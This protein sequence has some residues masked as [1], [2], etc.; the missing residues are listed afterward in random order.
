MRP[1]EPFPLGATWDGRGTNF[2]IFSEV[3]ERVELC[4]FDRNGRETRV[5]LPERTAFCWH[6][7]LRGV[8]PGQRYGFRVHGPWDPAN[9]LRCNP[10]KLLVD[11]YARAIT[12]GIEWNP[13]VFPYPLGGD[14]LQRDDDDNAAYMPKA[15]VVDDAFDWEGDRSAAP[16]AARDGHLRSAPE[17]IHEAASRI[18]RRPS[19]ARMPGSRTRPRSSTCRRS[20]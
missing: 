14:D 9:G 19:A 5:N 15:V 6:A 16:Q 2:S 7:Y 12:G 13:P 1:G 8:G 18:F 20:A 17:G 11:P 3:A 10:A 4:L